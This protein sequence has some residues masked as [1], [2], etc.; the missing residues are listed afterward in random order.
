[1]SLLEALET[2]R[3]LLESKIIFDVIANRLV[4]ANK[5][6]EERYILTIHGT[7]L[8]VFLNESIGQGFPFNENFQCKTKSEVFLKVSEYFKSLSD[9]FDIEWKN[10]KENL[11]ELEPN[12]KM[13]KE[14]IIKEISFQIKD[15]E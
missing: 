13:T 14:E 7:T 2:R 1:M 10:W 3:E 9:K 4:I 12:K 11:T 8:E 6:N 5:E 15:M